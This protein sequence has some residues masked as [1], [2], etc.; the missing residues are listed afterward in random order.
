MKLYSIQN[1]YS[2]KILYRSV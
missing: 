2:W 1:W